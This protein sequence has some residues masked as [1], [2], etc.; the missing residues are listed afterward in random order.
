MNNKGFTLI[1]IIA[2]VLI[3]V[4]LSMLAIINGVGKS[5]TN[6][7]NEYCKSN[8]DTLNSMA[9]EYFND[10]FTLVP[11]EIGDKAE[12]TARKLIEEKYIDKL[13]DYDNKPCDLDNSKVIVVKT[14]SK[15]Y[16]YSYLLSCGV[17][18]D[19]SKDNLTRKENIKPDV[20][21]TPDGGEN[22]LDKDINIKINLI[23]NGVPIYNY[24]YEI[25]KR[26]SNTEEVIGGV[27]NYEK[28]KGNSINIKL[29]TKGIY[30]IKT[31]VINALGNKTEKTSKDYIL[32]YNFNC[33]NVSFTAEYNEGYGY[34][35]L[36]ENEWH[37]GAYRFR[38]N[39]SGGITSYDV[40]LQTDSDDENRYTKVISNATNN[41]ELS[42]PNTLSH[43]Y[44]IYMVA[45]D[46]NGNKCETKRYTY[47]Q[48]NIPPRCEGSGGSSKW[49]NQNVT[50]YGTAYDDL[51]TNYQNSG[52]LRNTSRTITYETNDKYSPG[53]VYDNAGNE[54]YCDADQ[55]VK[56]DKTK[57]VCET[58][59]GNTSWTN[60]SVKVFGN[61]T[62][63]ESNRVSS[64]CLNSQVEKEI[65]EET[66]EF[67]SPGRV[68]DNAGNVSDE[69]PKK[70]VRIDKT[71]PKCTHSGD[72][73]TWT[74]NNR[75]I[76]FGCTDEHGCDSSYDGGSI[77]FNTNTKTSTIPA[78]TIK[79]VAGNTIECD[80]RVAN[81]YVDKCT[82]T[83]YTT[84][85]GPCSAECGSGTKKG[86]RTYTSTFGS[87]FTC[88]V[89]D[90]SKSCT[91]TNCPSPIPK[92]TCNIRGNTI[93]STVDWYCNVHHHYNTTAYRHYCTDGNGKI[94]IADHKFICPQSPY[95]PSDGY[96]ILDDSSG[97][98]EGKNSS[99]VTVV[100]TPK[101]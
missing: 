19:K 89:K 67:Y 62:D 25:Y 70:R 11:K 31:Y 49:T 8:A 80:A 79:D 58:T 9:K 53:T 63:P 81:V 61:C 5:I 12:V 40:Y 43:T 52:P 6:G 17:C 22:N 92:D 69:C 91:G 85:W 86:T 96:T 56:I 54:T 10:R 21:Y 4:M 7:H 23:D 28:Y 84:S 75:K 74:K 97:S 71:N 65:S 27:T 34:Q 57:P 29:N 3:L 93:I 60:Q 95:G 68:Y 88:E 37:K 82:E 48:D 32:N 99:N 94:Y 64:G 33:D 18:T 30:F 50:I 73:K 24:K 59:G 55:E 2:V 41:K 47:K 87:F 44:R 83:D 101:N 66:D 51:G 46:E 35:T 42:F 15:S 16:E 76:K 39:V 20:E 13:T 78:Y 36:N 100:A 45:Y 77:T 98:L 38:F 26:E 1:E 72:S 90:V 14:E